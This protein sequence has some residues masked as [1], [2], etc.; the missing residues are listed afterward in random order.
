MEFCLQLSILVDDRIG[1]GSEFG[2]T[3]SEGDG[4]L[5]TVKSVLMITGDGLMCLVN[6]YL[7]SNSC[8]SQAPC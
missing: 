5:Y 2:K 1:S 4:D 7:Y 6:E 8:M 3:V